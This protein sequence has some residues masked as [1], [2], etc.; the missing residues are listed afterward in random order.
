MPLPLIAIVGPTASGKSSLAMALAEQFNGEIVCADSRTVFKGMD[1]GTAKPSTSD[2]TKIRHYGLDVIQPDQAFTAAQFKQ[3][4]EQAI[5]TIVSRGKLP[6]LVGGTGLYVDAVLFNYSFAAPGSPDRERLN[7]LTVHEL[8]QICRDKNIAIPEN[9]QNKRHLVRAIETGGTQKGQQTLR[10]NTLV[11]GLDVPKE[12]LNARIEDRVKEMF[13]AGVE[14]EALG[15][16]NKYG[17]DN[18]ALKA[19]IY[20]VCRQLQEGKLDP[21]QAIAQATQADR[22]LAK[23][24]RTWLKRNVYV[25]WGNW[26]DSFDKIQQFIEQNT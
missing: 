19:N 11:I 21:T 23:R 5:H 9:S 24:Q 26:R 14:Q 6:I 18:E 4:A 8:Q 20:Q 10:S 2:R 1:I 7:N 3:L 15:L 13:A 16:A 25:N 17:W 12:T 22:R